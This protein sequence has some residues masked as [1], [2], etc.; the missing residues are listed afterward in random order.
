MPNKNVGVKLHNVGS[1][2]LA[3]HHVL[4][5]SMPLYLVLQKAVAH[6]TV[7]SMRHELINGF[8]YSHLESI[9]DSLARVPPSIMAYACFTIGK[10]EMPPKSQ[11]LRYGLV[12][13]VTLRER[14]RG[15]PEKPTRRD[16]TR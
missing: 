7:L 14:A 8:G 11:G 13:E 2:F 12:H 15:K 10:L 4:C 3:L 6:M 1:C 9:A 5:T 16:S